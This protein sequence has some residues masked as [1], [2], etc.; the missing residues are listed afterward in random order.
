MLVLSR[1]PGEEVIIAS[2]I[3]VTVLAIRGNRVQLGFSAPGDAAIMRSELA[4]SSEAPTVRASPIS[5]ES[6]VAE[7]EEVRRRRRP[8]FRLHSFP[9]NGSQA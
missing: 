6:K 3:R 5:G 9:K 4:P 2:N 7:R 8:R 1:R